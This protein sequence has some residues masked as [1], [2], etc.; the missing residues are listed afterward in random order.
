MQT[1]LTEKTAKSTFGS[2]GSAAL[3]RFETISTMK[4]SPIYLQTEVDLPPLP[5][6]EYKP[7][8]EEFIAKVVTSPQTQAAV[9]IS[10]SLKAAKN[11]DL[12]SLLDELQK[13]VDSVANGSLEAA[14]SMA[15]MQAKTLQFVFHDL[16]KDA[17]AVRNTLRFDYLLRLAFR[18]Q[19]QSARTLETLTALK[20]PAVFTQQLNMADQQV[21]TNHPPTKRSK[22]APKRAAPKHKTV[23]LAQKAKTRFSQ[24]CR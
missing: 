8:D 17:Y 14:E 22:P 9:T 19:A 11:T 13:N 7:G 6:V 4:V 2:F 12:A 15:L 20:K 16:L 10:S 23:R 21:V 24:R 18:A 5:D 1:P 3:S